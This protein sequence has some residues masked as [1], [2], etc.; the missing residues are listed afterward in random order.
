MQ[1]D[2][3]REE[4]ADL[5]LATGDADAAVRGYRDVMPR[6]IDEDELR[7]LEVIDRRRRRAARAPRRR[8]AADRRAGARDR[9]LPRGRAPRRVERG[10]AERRAAAV[11][12]RPTPLLVRQLHRSA[13]SARPGARDAHRD[14]A[15][16]DRG[17]AAARRR[18]VRD[19]RRGGGAAVVRRVR[20]APERERRPARG[21]GAAPRAV[22]ARGSERGSAR[23]GRATPRAHQPR[24]ARRQRRRRDAARALLQAVNDVLRVVARHG[25]PL[26]GDAFQE[27]AGAIRAWVPFA[28]MGVLTPEEPLTTGP[29]ASASGN[30]R[31]RRRHRRALRRLG[32]ARGAPHLARRA[33]ARLPRRRRGDLRA[34]RTL[35]LR[36]RRARWRLRTRHGR[37]RVRL[38]RVVPARRERRAGARRRRDHGLRSAL[39][40]RQARQTSRCSARSRPRSATARP[41]CSR[42]RASGG[43]R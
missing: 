13:R 11:P 34:P 40:E 12:A 18:R 8:R 43:W 23:R 27:L 28:Q 2:R 37:G 5:A 21:D 16:R 1:R 31:R 38:V 42:R 7:T 33:R 39:P 35:P 29:F 9:S 25:D 17:R 41:A 30:V 15:R 26:T 19:G 10:R 4:L 22:H 20:G 32:D 3:A 24:P 6:V 14:R 36:R